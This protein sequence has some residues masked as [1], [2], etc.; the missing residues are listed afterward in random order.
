[1][2]VVVVVIIVVFK[3][4]RLGE[5]V[6]FLGQPEKWLEQKECAM[7]QAFYG[8]PCPRSHEKTQRCETDYRTR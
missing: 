7:L 6:L 4:K 3:G 5:S 1:M 2:F 8:I